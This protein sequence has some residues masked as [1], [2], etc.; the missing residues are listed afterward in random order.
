MN[1][2]YTSIDL[3]KDVVI[4]KTFLCYRIPDGEF[5][6]VGLSVFS[7]KVCGIC[8]ASYQDVGTTTTNT[9]NKVPN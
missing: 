4:S 9:Y 8:A 5:E 1:N 2:L 7:N 6:L 3:N